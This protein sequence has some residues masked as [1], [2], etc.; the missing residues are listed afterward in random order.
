[1]QSSMWVLKTHWFTAFLK[2]M[3]AKL[4]QPSLMCPPG[5]S[6]SRRGDVALCLFADLPPPSSLCS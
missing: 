3:P 2:V 1:M 4:V 6:G 5:A